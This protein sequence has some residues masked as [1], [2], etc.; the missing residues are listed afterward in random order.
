MKIKFL[1][2]A[3]TV[4]GSS[5]VLTSGSGQAILID[6]GMFQGL[7]AIEELNY[8]PYAYDPSKLSG[9]ILTHAHLDHCGRLPILLPK[10]FTGKVWMTPA[11]RDLTE[12]SLLDAAKIAK[13][14]QK[15]FLYDKDLVEQM[16][17]QF[18]TKEYR[19]PFQM[20][21]F[22][23]TF[24][25]AGHILGSA[26]V[27]IE[28]KSAN[29]DIRK[30][31]FSGD[32]GNSPEDLLEP[33]EQIGSADA[34][35]MESTYG[36]SL[37][38]KED[39]AETLLKEVQTVEKT[40]GTLLL[41][42]FSLERTQELLH[43]IRHLKEDG[44]IS[45]RT[46]V[47]M[48][49]PMAEHAT[50]IYLNYPRLFND[51]VRE[52]LQNGNPFDFPGIEL[53]QGREESEAIYEQPGSKVIIAGGGM[54]TG[55]RI[56]THAAHY[57]PMANTRLLILGYQGEGTLGR[58]LQEGTTDVMIDKVSVKVAA[59]VTSTRAMSS[60]ADQGQLLTWLKNIQGVKKVFLTH[61]ED[62]ARAALSEKITASLS[63]QDVTLPKMNEEIA[64]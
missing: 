43:I 37:H 16:L 41:P 50:E 31:V 36:D 17:G 49:S 29:G 4:T 26:T 5:Y 33:T 6:L 21:D 54:M 12:L 30:I 64:L 2:A 3:G 11:T 32:L 62:P 53:V 42:S 9:A 10:G 52:E 44:Q 55:G 63:L 56:V 27:E 40:G 14:N 8:Q 39:P 59:T 45:A 35:V 24:R 7:P 46:P 18:A 61:G 19:T 28:D 51:H 38:P 57:L 60:H 25:D 22:S 15:P 58:A 47:Y 13:T 48:D 20:G 23:V 1:G 34:V